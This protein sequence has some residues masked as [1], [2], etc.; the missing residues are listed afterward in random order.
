MSDNVVAMRFEKAYPV[1]M[2]EK[3]MFALSNSIVLF[4]QL[5]EKQK[6]VSHEQTFQIMKAVQ[7]FEQTLSNG[8][9]TMVKEERLPEI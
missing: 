9:F 1:R 4:F 8:K 7:K 2:T 5:N 6:L 3:E